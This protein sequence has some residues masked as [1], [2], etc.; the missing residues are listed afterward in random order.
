[1]GIEIKEYTDMTIKICLKS[2]ARN[3]DFSIIAID[4]KKAC[5]MQPICVL[6][7]YTCNPNKKMIKK[8]DIDIRKMLLYL[9]N[10]AH[11]SKSLLN[12]FKR[13]QMLNSICIP[14]IDK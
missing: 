1:M 4:M 9:A 12:I 6:G 13:I 11:V 3:R 2:V 8:L 14:K 10:G 5:Y 7:R